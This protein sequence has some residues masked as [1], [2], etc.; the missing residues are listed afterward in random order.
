[1][2]AT[3]PGLIGFFST[4]VTSSWTCAP[5]SGNPPTWTT[6]TAGRGSRRLRQLLADDGRNAAKVRAAC[7]ESAHFDH[8]RPVQ[9]AEHGLHGISRLLREETLGRQRRE[10]KHEP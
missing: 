1:M 2:N 9:L 10:V 4:D 5:T 3:P 8:L 6:V 7:D